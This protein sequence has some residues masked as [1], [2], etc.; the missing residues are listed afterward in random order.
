MEAPSTASVQWTV[1]SLPSEVLEEILLS[2]LLR[3]R[4]L[5]RVRQVCWRLHHIVGRL[6]TKVAATRSVWG[7]VWGLETTPMTRDISLTKVERVGL[8]FWLHP[9]G[10]VPSVLSE[11]PV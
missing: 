9:R 2:P 5:C 3:V 4:D 6:W 1:L 7:E 8:C 11:M 10:L